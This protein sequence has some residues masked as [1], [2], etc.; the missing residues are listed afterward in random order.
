ML[1]QQLANAFLRKQTNSSM[2]LNKL[3][4][5][6]SNLNSEDLRKQTSSLSVA[7][8]VKTLMTLGL[9]IPFITVTTRRLHDSNKSGWVQL[10]Y[11]I[12]VLGWL[13]MILFLVTEGNDGRNQYGEDPLKTDD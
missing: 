1:K 7:A 4:K 8:A 2:D 9:A 5:Q 6:A 11:L 12:P 13:L 3:L 10:L